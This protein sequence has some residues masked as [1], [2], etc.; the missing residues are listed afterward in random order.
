MRRGLE[1]EGQVASERVTVVQYSPALLLCLV[2]LFIVLLL[3]IY[4]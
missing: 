4:K 2:F 3:E 1:Q